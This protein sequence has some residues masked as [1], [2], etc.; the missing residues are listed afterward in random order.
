MIECKGKAELEKMRTANLIVAKVIS[1]LGSLIKAGV[2]TKELDTVAEEMIL[3]EGGRPAFKGYRG[4]PASVCTSVNDEIV[5]GIPRD[6]RV[7]VQGD[8]LAIDVGV[9]YQGYYGDAAYT[10]PVGEISEELHRLLTVTRDSLYRG[11][12]M[13]RVGNR[14]SDISATILANRSRCWGTPYQTAFRTAQPTL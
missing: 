10:F 13:V 7:L 3:D 12:E 8:I 2:T 9:C 14:V 6:D 1:R 11:I 5:H 4:F